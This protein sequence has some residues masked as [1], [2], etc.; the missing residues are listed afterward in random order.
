VRYKL[1]ILNALANQ[2][3]GRA[4]LDDLRRAAEL[5]VASLDEMQLQRFTAL[6]DIDIFQARLVLQD[7]AECQITDRGLALL[8]W[9]EGTGPPSLEL[10]SAAASLH[11]GTADHFMQ[12]GQS[13]KPFDPKPRM[14]ADVEIPIA[15]DG[16]RI[17]A[18]GLE[19]RKPQNRSSGLQHT[20][21]FVV[22]RAQ[23]LARSLG[24][25]IS[26]KTQSMLT[27]RRPHSPRNNSTSSKPGNVRSIQTGANAAFGLLALLCVVAC[28]LAAIALGQIQ[29]LKSDVA[30][31]RRELVPL[32]ERLARFEQI[33]KQRQDLDQ[34]EEAQNQSETEKKKADSEV[35]NAPASLNLTREEI[36][37]I[38]DYIK[39]ALS[40]GIAAPE[41]NVGDAVSGAMIPLPSQ[42][43]DK[44]PKLLGARF[45]TRNGAIVIIKRD[46]HQADA[47]LPPN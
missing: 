10:C 6:G 18:T 29:S 45:T 21:G 30:V 26:T 5:V 42:L 22:Q 9:L 8:D 47:V 3:G 11:I 1:A 44:I 4:T 23:K 13:S 39:P 20:G 36:Q 25:F 17:G 32:K 37:L 35:R 31:L 12:S 19:Y 7:A 28:V 38:R 33:E 40:T 41:I 46:S 14:R 2:P 27:W 43:M 24:A 34:P 15:A 16:H